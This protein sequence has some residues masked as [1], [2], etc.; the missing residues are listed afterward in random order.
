MRIN[1]EKK[2]GENR[3]S[4]KTNDFQDIV[5]GKK[6]DA[7][8]A[9]EQFEAYD[10]L[11]DDLRNSITYQIKVISGPKVTVPCD[12]AITPSAY[13]HFGPASFLD[14]PFSFLMTVYFQSCTDWNSLGPISLIHLTVHFDR[15]LLGRAEGNFERQGRTERNRKRI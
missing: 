11:I 9:Q 8:T 7:S 2:T 15:P 12:Q 10:K 3:L 1:S 4:E 5:E 13:G 6:E 14:R